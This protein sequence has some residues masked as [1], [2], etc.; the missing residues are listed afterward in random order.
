[1]SEDAFHYYRAN[2]AENPDIL[3]YF[4]EATPVG[5][6]E[7]AR[8][9]SRPTRRSQKRGLEDL[10][11]IPWV[12]GWMQSRHVLPGYFGVGYALERFLDADPGARSRCCKP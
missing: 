7:H 6:L 1:M 5:E 3:P 10:R 2:V 4:E 9:G 8:I 11:A 12:F